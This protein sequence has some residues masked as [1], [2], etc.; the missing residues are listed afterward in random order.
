METKTEMVQAPRITSR[1]CRRLGQFVN[2][3]V[4]DGVERDFVDSCRY[5]VET[6]G[7]S[8]SEAGRALVTAEGTAR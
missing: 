1:R 3:Y 2:V 6:Y 7:W 8:A 4:V 5:L